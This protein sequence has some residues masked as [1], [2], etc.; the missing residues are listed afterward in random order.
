MS[1]WNFCIIF[2]VFWSKTW[3]PW[4][5][6]ECLLWTRWTRGEGSVRLVPLTIRNLH[7]AEKL[8]LHGVVELPNWKW[9]NK[10]NKT[11]HDNKSIL[12]YS[13]K[14]GKVTETIG[15]RKLHA[16]GG[17][18]SAWH[19]RLIDRWDTWLNMEGS[20]FGCITRWNSVVFQHFY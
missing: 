5:C 6:L 3:E 18:L 16:A 14:E 1:C 12:F 10:S 7:L 13:I 17:S 20:L 11:R 9:S 8:A 4:N 2:N 15:G 19:R